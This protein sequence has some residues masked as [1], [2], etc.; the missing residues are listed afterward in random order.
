[1]YVCTTFVTIAIVFSPKICCIYC[2]S[3]FLTFSLIAKGKKHLRSTAIFSK[4]P[5]FKPSSLLKLTL[6]S[7]TRTDTRI[8]FQ[9]LRFSIY[10]NPLREVMAVLEVS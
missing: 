6:H 2:A 8:L 10:E 3:Q 1:M 7:S 9:F 4:V 5:S